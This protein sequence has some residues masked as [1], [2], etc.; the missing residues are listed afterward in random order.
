MNALFPSSA[1][2]LHGRVAR[3][4]AELLEYVGGGNNVAVE[5]PSVARLVEESLVSLGWA[6]N[7]RRLAIFV[8]KRG[9]L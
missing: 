2:C 9:D 3:S 5:S 4:T 1:L 7:W 8:T 6:A